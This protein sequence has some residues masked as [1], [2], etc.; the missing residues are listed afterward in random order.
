M[1]LRVHNLS[2]SIDGFVAG[3]DQSAESPLGVDAMALHDWVRDEHTLADQHFLDRGEENIGATIMGRNMF[4]PIRGDW[5]DDTWKGWWGEEPPFH[6][7]VFVLTHHPRPSF[8]MA[9]GT[10][11]HFTDDPIETVLARADEAAEGKDVRLGGGASA[12]TQFL[13][14]GLVDELHLAVVPILLGSG[15]SIYDGWDHSGYE[16]SRVVTSSNLMHVVYRKRA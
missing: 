10:T 12:V 8:D 14:A 7:Q 6:H 11:F 4:G 1:T 2:V 5:P 16:R 13:A 9:G 3:P 15:E